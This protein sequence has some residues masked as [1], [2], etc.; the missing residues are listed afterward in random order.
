MDMRII[1]FLTVLIVVG[2]ALGCDWYYTEGAMAQAKDDGKIKE[3]RLEAFQFGFSP[4]PVVVEKGDIVKLEI[5]SRDVPHGVYIKEYN[6]N[7]P[8][9]KGEIKRV[10]FFADKEGEF[11]I[12]CSVFCGSGHSNMKGRLVVTK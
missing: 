1:G 2:L 3:I 11:N 8:V 6:I 4:N 10:E 5:T 9:K 7:V 12:Q